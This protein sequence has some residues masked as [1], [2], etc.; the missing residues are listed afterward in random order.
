MRV[1][2]CVD[3]RCLITGRCADGLVVKGFA[4]LGK[5]A[6]LVAAGFTDEQLCF[7]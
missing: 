2:T 7:D 1:I 3:L 6:Q 4:I 5:Y